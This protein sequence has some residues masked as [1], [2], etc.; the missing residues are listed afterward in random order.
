[1]RLRH[2]ESMG[3]RKENILRWISGG[4]ARNGTVSVRK[5]FHASSAAGSCVAASRMIIS[6]DFAG[7]A[8]IAIMTIVDEVIALWMLCDYAGKVDVGP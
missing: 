2:T 7:F 6:F 3:L 8:T 5:C 1:M 4:T